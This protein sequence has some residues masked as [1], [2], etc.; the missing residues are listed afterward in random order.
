MLNL[1]CCV[2]CRNNLLDI[3]SDSELEV[4]TV[5]NNIQQKYN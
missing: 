1:V 5:S 4:A 2:T 3:M